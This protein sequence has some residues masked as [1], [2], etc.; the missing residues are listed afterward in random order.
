[1][2]NGRRKLNQNE[3]T[4][5]RKAPTHGGM[6]RMPRA[7]NKKKYPEKT[8]IAGKAKSKRSDDVMA[9]C[10]RTRAR[11]KRKVYAACA[12]ARAT[13]PQIRKTMLI[14]RGEESIVLTI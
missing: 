3:R 6:M 2:L 7:R 12:I 13:R 10:V 9:E 8:A 11:E 4:V 5:S 14:R 1:V